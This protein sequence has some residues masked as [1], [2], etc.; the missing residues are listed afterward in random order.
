[1]GAT[2]LEHYVFKSRIVSAGYDKYGNPRYS[3]SIPKEVVEKVK[4]LHGREVIVHVIV[5]DSW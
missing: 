1:M 5:P 2:S 3:I 4:H